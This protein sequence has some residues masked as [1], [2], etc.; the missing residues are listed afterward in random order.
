MLGRVEEG[1][2]GNG[3]DTPELGSDCV[4]LGLRP[5]RGSV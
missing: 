5:G 4:Q 3:E 1:S 2:W